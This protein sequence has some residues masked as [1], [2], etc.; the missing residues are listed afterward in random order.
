MQLK[1]GLLEVLESVALFLLKT[2]T[3]NGKNSWEFFVDNIIRFRKERD[4][5][6]VSL[7]N[8][9]SLS[10]PA[11]SVKFLYCEPY[12]PYVSDCSVS[13]NWSF[14]QEYIPLQIGDSPPAVSLYSCVNFD[15]INV[16]ALHFKVNLTS[17]LC[18]VFYVHDWLQTCGYKTRE[19]W[20]LFAEVREK[21]VLGF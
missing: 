2:E 3:C 9:N 10:C 7:I 17:Y 13:C 5:Y 15:K 21:S 16:L 14:G 20:G 4:K 6:K 11:F 19:L 18:S 8:I 12:S 1:N